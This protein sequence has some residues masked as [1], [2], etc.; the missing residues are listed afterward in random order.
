MLPPVLDACC[1]SRMF[2]FNKKDDRALFFDQRK[3]R[4]TL[5]DASSKGGSR[6]L[7]IAPD[8]IGDFTDLPFSDSLFSLV[9]FD[10]PHL[11]RNGSTGWMGKKYG[12]LKDGWPEML[13]EGF[14]ECFRVLK[15]EGVLIFKWCSTEIPLSK[16]LELTPERPLIGHKSGKQ[17]RTHWVTFLKS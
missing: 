4:H 11:Q 17:Q 12:T 9:I 15:P 3:E 8:I 16:I 5:K 6:E 7:V 14:A 10:P 13:R 1:G 2:W